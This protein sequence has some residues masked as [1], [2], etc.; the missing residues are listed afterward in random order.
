MCLSY[1]QNKENKKSTYEENAV[2]SHVSFCKLFERARKIAYA[3][4]I[5]D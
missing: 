3:N 1:F 2:F 5:D 4:E